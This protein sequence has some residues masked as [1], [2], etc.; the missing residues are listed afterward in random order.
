MWTRDI[1]A[2][3]ATLTLPKQLLI[4][5]RFPCA[6]IVKLFL[7]SGPDHPQ[8]IQTQLKGNVTMYHVNVDAVK[9]ML[10]GQL[11]PCTT[12]IL[13][14][15]IAVTFI[16]HSNIT[17]SKLRSLFRVRQKVVYKARLALKMV[18][19][20]PGSTELDIDEEMVNAL[21][22]DEVPEEIYMAVWWD[23]DEDVIAWESA[24]CVPADQDNDKE[25]NQDELSCL[26][27]N[28]SL[29]STSDTYDAHNIIDDPDVVPL[30]YNGIV[31]ADETQ[32]TPE[33]LMHAAL[34]KLKLDIQEQMTKEGGYLIH[35]GGFAQDF[36]PSLSKQLDNGKEQP[37]PSVYAFP[38][39]F[40]YGVGGLEYK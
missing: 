22:E 34:K 36:G 39:L 19:K 20:H 10:E 30:E 40:L 13:P 26:N 27:A 28:G 15:L 31:A 18:T 29:V 35:H 14:Y 1:P 3:L 7:K 32:I 2:A 6:Y 8:A 5:L 23:K 16:G 12:S 17:K 21:P 24:G 25:G 11:I 9:Q 4:A 33:E 38:H 37:N